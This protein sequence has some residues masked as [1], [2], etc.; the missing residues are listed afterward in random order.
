MFYIVNVDFNQDFVDTDHVQLLVNA[1]S[2]EK[3]IA[4]VRD[5]TQYAYKYSVEELGDGVCGDRPFI[6]L[7][8]DKDCIDKLHEANSIEY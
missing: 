1:E 5:N 8:D 7:P 3:A 6:H 2:F 4:V